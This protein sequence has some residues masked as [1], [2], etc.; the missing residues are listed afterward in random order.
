M[1]PAVDNYERAMGSYLRLGDQNGL[2]GCLLGLGDLW[3][4]AGNAGLAMD[5]LRRAVDAYREVGNR[6]D[7]AHALIALG[8]A[9]A[10]VDRTREAYPAWRAALEILEKLR[11]PAATSVK[12][13][14]KA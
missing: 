14:L 8:D 4:K 6:A 1:R 2:G 11:L 10:L 5:Y 7:E 3:L 13:R 9:L 12:D